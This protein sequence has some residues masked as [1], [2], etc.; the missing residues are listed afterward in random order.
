MAS[1]TINIRRL[2]FYGA[3]LAGCGDKEDAREPLGRIGALPD[4]A[5]ERLSSLVYLN[6]AL[7]DTARGRDAMELAVRGDRDLVVAYT[8]SAARSHAVLRSL[9]FTA[10]ARSLNL[11]VSRLTT[12]NRRTIAVRLRIEDAVPMC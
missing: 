4:G 10:V 9:R 2:G 1:K 5:C 12:P 8:I 7:A 6:L 11:G 3:T